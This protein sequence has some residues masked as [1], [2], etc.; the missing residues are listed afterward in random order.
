MT[1]QPYCTLTVYIVP[2][3]ASPHS[4]W[5]NGSQSYWGLSPDAPGRLA[6]LANGLRGPGRWGLVG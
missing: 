1:A 6:P 3:A 5:R 2:G 4:Q